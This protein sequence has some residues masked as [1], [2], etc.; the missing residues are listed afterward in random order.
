MS[1]PLITTTLAVRSR[2]DLCDYAR[3]HLKALLDNVVEHKAVRNCATG[4]RC[5]YQYFPRIIGTKRTL[6]HR[7]E[8]LAAER[9]VATLHDL[10]GNVCI[11]R[12]DVCSCCVTRRMRDQS[13]CGSDSAST[14]RIF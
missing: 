6:N 4:L 2:I 3:G 11:A 9:L 13:I 5:Q 7:D 8:A 1:G 12:M 10:V 14:R